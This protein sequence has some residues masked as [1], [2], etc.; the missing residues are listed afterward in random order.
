MRP[1]YGP[2]SPTPGIRSGREGEKDGTYRSRSRRAGCGLRR[3]AHR[4]RLANTLRGSGMAAA[5][6]RA[7][8]DGGERHGDSRGQARVRRRPGRERDPGRPLRCVQGDR[9]RHRPHARHRH[10][11]EP[12]AV[13]R[14]HAHARHALHAHPAQPLPAREDHEHRHVEGGEAPRSSEDP[15]PREPPRRIQGRFPRRGQ[16]DPVPLQ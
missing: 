11:H 3:L 9:K 16:P 8:R 4:R 5:R 7:V 13:H 6:R 1:R 14:E 2:S 12:R 15:P 10:R